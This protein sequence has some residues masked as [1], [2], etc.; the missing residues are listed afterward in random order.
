MVTFGA[1]C[2][3]AIETGKIF[4]KDY[5]LLFLFGINILYLFD[6]ITVYKTAKLR[7]EI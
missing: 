3:T 6:M 7:N 5:S 1:V 4:M 2:F